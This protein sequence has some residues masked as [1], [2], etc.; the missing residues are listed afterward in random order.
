[1]ERCKRGIEV[2]HVIRDAHVQVLDLDCLKRACSSVGL[3]FHEG[4]CKYRIGGTALGNCSH[5]ISRSEGDAYELGV[6]LR[7]HGGWKIVAHHGVQDVK[8][9][10]LKNK[11]EL[12][13]AYAREA[14]HTGALVAGQDDFKECSL[15]DGAVILSYGAGAVDENGDPGP[16]FV[17]K[18]RKGC[19]SCVYQD[20]MF[21]VYDLLI[22][23]LSNVLQ[24]GGRIDYSRDGGWTSDLS[25][26]HGPLL[27]PFKTYSEA[28][29]AE[30]DWHE[31]KMIHG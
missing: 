27:G 25:S 16:R 28:L 13:D 4:R 29:T 30:H 15:E 14:F 7:R 11:W 17:M 1:V 10:P 3:K 23:R 22:F 9:G 5:A 19:I 6:L 20:R 21:P 24:R 18:I 2:T 8:R 12:W 31:Q 26:M